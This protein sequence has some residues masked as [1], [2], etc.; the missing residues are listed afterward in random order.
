MILGFLL[1]N[2]TFCFHTYAQ[3]NYRDKTIIQY[4]NIGIPIDSMFFQE[5]KPILKQEKISDYKLYEIIDITSQEKDSR[6]ILFELRGIKTPFDDH[7]YMV[8][9]QNK[10]YMIDEKFVNILFKKG[11]V[12]KLEHTAYLTYDD[13][14]SP[15]LI[16]QYCDNK[17]QLIDKYSIFPIN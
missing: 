8:N 5:L 10:T 1:I 12:F 13:I 4:Y 16:L 15:I 17:I 6:K 11:Q 3:S 14:E 9:Y 2:C 7:L